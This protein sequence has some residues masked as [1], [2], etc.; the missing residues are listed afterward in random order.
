MKILISPSWLATI[1]SPGC[2][3]YSCELL[4]FE[5]R[6][7]SMGGVSSKGYWDVVSLVR[8]KGFF[9]HQLEMKLTSG[10][11]ICLGGMS[12]VQ[13][14]QISRVIEER[15]Q[16]LLNLQREFEQ[17]TDLLHMESH[18]CA[19]ATAGDFWIAQSD[20]VHRKSA[21]A[22]LGKYF[23]IPIRSAGFNTALIELLEQT[24]EFCENPAAFK[25]RC[26]QLFVQ[27]ECQLYKELLDTVEKNP[28]TQEQREAVVTNEDSTLVVASAG[29]GKTS[30]LVGKVGYLVEKQMADPGEIL[31]LAFN[32]NA[33]EEIS[34]RTQARL[35]VQVDVHTFHSFGLNVIAKANERKPSLAQ[36]VEDQYQYLQY[37][38]QVVVRVI[39]NPELADEVAEY[40]I[41][42][43]RPYKDAFDFKSLGEYYEFIN[44]NK[45]SI[46]LKGEVVKSLEEL[47]LAN[48]LYV[49][50]ISYVYEARYEF[51]TATIL[52]RQYKP[53]F[54]LPDYGIYIE[55]FALDKNNHTPPFIDE[56][57]YVSSVEWK[58]KIHSKNN[59]T[60]VETYSHEKRDGILTSNLREKL[61]SRGVEFN[62]L[63]D[64][65]L[66]D[67]LNKCGYVSEFAKICATFLNL[68]KGREISL[69][70]FK[71][72]LVD[73]G[74]Q[75]ER[76]ISFLNIF[77]PIYEIY[78][79]QLRSSGEIDFHD[80][81][82]EA[83]HLIANARFTSGYKFLLVDEFQDISVGRG[84]LLQSIQKAN[85][86]LKFL[87]VGDDWQSIYRFSGS[88]IG[89]MTNFEQYFG[90]T[91]HLLLSETFRFNNRVESVA[92]KFIQVNP[93]QIKKSIVT[94]KS[95]NQ[96]E[97]ILF[98]PNKKTGKFLESIVAEIGARVGSGKATVL[99]LGRY[100]H[101]GEGLEYRQLAKI[102]PNCTFEFSTI[103]RA[104]GREAD[105]VI[106][107]DLS[108]GS[109]GFPSEIVDDPIVTSILASG[110]I[111]PHS[112]ERRLFYVALTRAKESVYLI[113][114]PSY[115]S[116][117]F[118]ELVGGEYDIKKV[119]V[120]KEYRRLC[121][122]C[123]SGRML[124]KEGPKGLF[125]GCEHFPLCT[126]TANVCK[127]CGI[128]YLNKENGRYTCDNELCNH[129][130]NCCPNCGDGMLLE[131]KGKFGLFYG[132]SNY[133]STGCDYT[134]NV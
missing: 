122:A 74:D 75:Y 92:S 63:D 96:P 33:K 115:P 43:F 79:S 21:M 61:E 56:V 99:L 109:Y 60:L 14:N 2:V 90:Y 126:H 50:G 27:R 10:G 98:S 77:A 117:F 133:F 82:H 114:D 28:L 29:S 17:L 37:I 35:G 101:N 76:V 89:L 93:A 100:N 16:F 105:F 113:G 86:G 67:S 13:I 52:R 59:T 132:C 83:S 5:I 44:S 131:K 111:F 26:N 1:F 38:N 58:R 104:K 41:E 73:D 42:H 3:S 95:S 106:V 8:S 72:S 118:T 134:K 116:L 39:K 125:F 120:G 34:E 49:N 15:G 19:S 107:L 110:E 6:Y 130:V 48:Y 88:D 31:I 32:R 24:K 85:P 127:A 123:K 7:S 121:P 78:Q 119:N 30:L 18:W 53:D 103:H 69:E 46:T 87:A 12:E 91:K 40:F 51:D 4:D 57:E 62:P 102:A 80:M 84:R 36:F 124:D 54:Y 23:N 11:A 47:V 70:E 71:A 55:H 66:F 20:L 65:Q 25:N 129:S 112:E 81:I 68:F 128:G 108:R 9:W 64:G 94:L 45:K 97:V 22:P